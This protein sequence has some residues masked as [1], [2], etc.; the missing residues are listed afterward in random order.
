MYRISALAAGATP[1]TAPEK[2]RVVDPD[3]I[4][5]RSPTARG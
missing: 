5:A 3:A 1:V 2:D 4:L